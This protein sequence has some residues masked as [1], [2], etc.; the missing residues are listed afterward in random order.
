MFEYDFDS[1][2]HLLLLSTT[3]ICTVVVGMIFKI[4]INLDI[5]IH[6]EAL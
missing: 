1:V 3:I 5:I 4:S 2:E 6:C